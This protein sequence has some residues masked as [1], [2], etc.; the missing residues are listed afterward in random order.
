MKL[1][2]LTFNGTFE[3]KCSY[4]FNTQPFIASFT[5][6]GRKDGMKSVRKFLIDNYKDFLKNKNAT[7]FEGFKYSFRMVVFENYTFRY[8]HEFEINP[9]RLKNF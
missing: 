7:S 1:Y 6:N 4:G 5:E 9:L 8:E 2:F 3:N